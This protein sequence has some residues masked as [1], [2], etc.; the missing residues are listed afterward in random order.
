VSSVLKVKQL[1]L[2]EADWTPADDALIESGIATLED[3]IEQLPW[4]TRWT[5]EPDYDPVD[6]VYKLGYNVLYLAQDRE[7]NLLFDVNGMLVFDLYSAGSGNVNGLQIMGRY[8]AP[9][10]GDPNRVRAHLYKH[11]A[12]TWKIELYDFEG[13]APLAKD[14]AADQYIPGEWHKYRLVVNGSVV[15]LQIDGEYAIEA[16]DLYLQDA[17]T[18]GLK[19]TQEAD[20]WWVGS[21]ENGH[22]LPYF[23][24]ER[25]GTV[26]LKT[27]SAWTVPATFQSF[28]RLRTS[29]SFVNDANGQQRG[30]LSY[31][32]RIYDHV[33][34]TWG[35]WQ[36]VDADGDLSGISANPGNGVILEITMDNAAESCV[37]FETIPGISDVIITYYAGF[38]SVPTQMDELLLLLK[39]ALDNDSAVAD[40]SAGWAPETGAMICDE[41]YHPPPA[42]GTRTVYICRG[43]TPRPALG[44]GRSGGEERFSFRMTHN[45]TIHP[46]SVYPSADPSNVI[47]ATNAL[48]QLTTQVVECLSCNDLDGQVEW[49]IVGDVNPGGRGEENS[50]YYRENTI[51]LEVFVGD[52]LT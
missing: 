35:E 14:I 20:V 6:Q 38:E 2:S 48:E 29:Y 25:S 32:I 41:E 27:T 43:S 46:A 8:Y 26:T 7:G 22:E 52:D 51:A 42:Y 1:A 18:V 50:Q 37:P 39:D 3:P 49:M 10:V 11:F 34:E 17:G 16:R 5:E 45:V 47:V 12:A 9:V 36:T 15:R 30:Q 23:A 33:T 31:R 44:Q 40:V 21:G 4:T 13:S 24:H 19:N 28:D